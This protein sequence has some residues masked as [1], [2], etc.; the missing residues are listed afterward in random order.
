MHVNVVKAFGKVDAVRSFFLSRK[1]DIFLV[2]G[3]MGSDLHGMH[4]EHM[5]R[6]CSCLS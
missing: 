2:V 1:R 3:E 4:D 5:Q 6:G